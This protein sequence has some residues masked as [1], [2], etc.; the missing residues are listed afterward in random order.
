MGPALVV[1]REV[2]TSGSPKASRQ[3]QRRTEALG[4][5]GPLERA[6]QS[7]GRN[8]R[9]SHPIERQQVARA[10]PLGRAHSRL[11]LDPK[12]QGLAFRRRFAPPLPIVP[13][14]PPFCRVVRDPRWSGLPERVT[15]GFE[16][17]T[18]EGDAPPPRQNPYRWEHKRR[19]GAYQSPPLPLVPIPW[20][21]V[22]YGA[23]AQAFA[24][25]KTT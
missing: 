4:G 21:E 22:P 6:G 14:G 11:L 8:P 23:E 12:P 10:R 19:P 24:C 20:V 5:A 3:T 7:G 17:Q 9:A 18:L 16:S 15:A 25:K 1:Q 2:A 13:W